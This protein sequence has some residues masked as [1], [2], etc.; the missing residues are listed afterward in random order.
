[1]DFQQTTGFGSATGDI[2]WTV[3]HGFKSRFSPA[4]VASEIED[5]E[6]ARIALSFL[7][8]FGIEGFREKHRHHFLIPSPVGTETASEPA[9]IMVGGSFAKDKVASA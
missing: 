4:G 9:Q 2:G 5:V 6:I 8:V 3:N 1:M 7:S